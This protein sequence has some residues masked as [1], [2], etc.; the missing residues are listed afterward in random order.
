MLLQFVSDWCIMVVIKYIV[1]LDKPSTGGDIMQ[2]NNDQAVKNSEL[3]TFSRLALA[4]ANDYESIYYVDI[5]KGL[6]HEAYH[7][8]APIGYR[9]YNVYSVEIL[10]DRV[11][12]SV[13][14]KTTL[15]YEKK[16]IVGQFPYGLPQILILD[17][18]FGG[19]KWVGKVDPSQLPCYMDIDWVRVYKYKGK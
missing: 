9:K 10:P 2:M 12:M 15:V 19:T 1:P 4:L 6:P 5:R 16:D 8:E 11:I 18:Q 14:G 7:V 13:N 17:M 3:V